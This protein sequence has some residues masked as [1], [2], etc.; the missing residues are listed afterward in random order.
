MT[1][2]PYLAFCALVLAPV[3]AQ[4]P[5]DERIRRVTA[6][7]A[8]RMSALHVPGVS[9]AVIHD[10]KIEWARGFGVT[11]ID[12]PAVTPDT[13]FQAASISKPVAALAALR[14]VQAGKLD[15]DVDVN[16]YLKSWKVA[17]NSFTSE[18][19]VT[20]RGLL[21]HSAGMTVH[22]FPGYASDAP[23]P[24]VLQILNGQKPANTSRIQVDTVPGSIWRYSG[25]GY[26]VV[27]LLLEEVTGQP[28]A[29]LMQDTVLRPIGMTRSTYEQPL[30]KARLSEV[31]MPYRQN[32]QPVA[33]GPHVYPEMAPAGLWTT[34]T[35]LARYAIEVQQALAG[36]S[37]RVIDAAMA[38]RMVTRVISNQ[39][40]GPGV[41]GS[42]TRPYFSHGGANEGYRCNL[43]AY[44]EGDG[45]IVMT[46]SDSGGRL[47]NEILAAV[48]REYGWPDF[49][50]AERR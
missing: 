42:P 3:A 18:K 21:S 8:E 45:L 24:S 4:S 49:Q 16:Q 33:G 23:V 9:I 2:R 27:Q 47:A 6:D 26:V 37:S 1:R 29:K 46:N 12:G 48:A 38:R 39:G 22:G 40:L 44:N 19:K 35:D 7:L 36:A 43:V 11:R 28:F 34:P 50:P 10:S 32:S 31:A 30:P 15:L 25:G 17:E 41:G 13:L 5:V 14:L 20:L